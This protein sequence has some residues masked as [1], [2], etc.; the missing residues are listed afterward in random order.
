MKWRKEC[1]VGAG[2]S[3]IHT[4][5]PRKL[6]EMITC[7][8]TATVLPPPCHRVKRNI[9]S[10]QNSS[11]YIKLSSHVSIH[12]NA[13]LC[14]FF[15]IWL[16]KE[17]HV[18]VCIQNNIVN[19]HNQ[20]PHFMPLF[21]LCECLFREKPI[22]VCLKHFMLPCINGK[23]SMR[24]GPLWPDPDFPQWPRILSKNIL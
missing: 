3:H 22:F 21:I 10:W 9:S 23:K 4:T 6:I 18:S 2:G 20:S 17:K 8:T 5:T 13:I 24:C 19:A 11:Q 12:G 7:N 15:R 1:Q 14:L 16:L